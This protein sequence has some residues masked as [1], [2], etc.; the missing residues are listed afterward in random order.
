MFVRVKRIGRY[1]Y[2]Y[3]VENAREGGRHVQRVVKSLGRRDA[4]E[5]SDLLD[6]LIASA[7]QHSRRSIVLSSVYRGELGRTSP[8]QHRSRFGV[9]RSLARGRLPR[10]AA[11][12]LRRLPLRLRCRARRLPDRAA[13]PDGLGSDRRASTCRQAIEIAGVESHAQSGSELLTR[14]WAS[15]KCRI[16]SNAA[17]TSLTKRIANCSDASVASYTRRRKD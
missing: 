3:L 7:A 4:V 17:S 2:L 12:A 1:E 16:G 8:S 15:G 6:G 10:G 9:R 11:P 5:N 13:S 14:G